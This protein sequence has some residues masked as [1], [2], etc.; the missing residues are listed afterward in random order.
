MVHIDHI[1]RC[2]FRLFGEIIFP[3]IGEARAQM[4]LFFLPILKNKETSEIHVRL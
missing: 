2:P 3:Q 1:T 4:G